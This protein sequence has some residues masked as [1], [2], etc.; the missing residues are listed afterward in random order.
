MQEFINL[1]EIDL[2]G[3]FLFITTNKFNNY[4]VYQD[5][6]KA[7]YLIETNKYFEVSSISELSFK[8]TDLQFKDS[9]FFVSKNS[10]ETL[11]NALLYYSDDTTRYVCFDT[12]GKVVK[13]ELSKEHFF[14]YI[15]KKINNKEI[16]Y[17]K[18]YKNKLIVVGID[19]EAKADFFAVYDEESKLFDKYYILKSDKHDIILTCLAVDEEEKQVVVV[20]YTEDEEIRPFLEILTI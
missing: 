3:K 8:Y 18:K 10:R 5:K 17:S 16:V 2:N 9:L 11:I 15:P 4:I 12:Y 13:E 19:E 14:N 1:Q 20:G 6:D 7:L